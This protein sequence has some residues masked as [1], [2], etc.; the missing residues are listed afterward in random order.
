[1]AVNYA[2]EGKSVT[3]IDF[4]GF[5]SFSPLSFSRR[6]FQYQLTYKYRI[7]VVK[8]KDKSSV[9]IPPNIDNLKS[10]DD[11]KNLELYGVHVGEILLTQLFELYGTSRIELED[12]KPNDLIK[13]LDFINRILSAIMDIPNFQFQFTSELVVFNG[14]KT[15]S[16]LCVQLARERGIRTRISE[17]ASSPQRF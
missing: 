11:I 17:R 16:A 3:I 13:E 14:R 6:F 10:L 4:S 7:K 8:V 5:R 9:K 15:T 1:M 2:K 12:L